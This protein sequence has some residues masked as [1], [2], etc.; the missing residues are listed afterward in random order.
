[1]AGTFRKARDMKEI[2]HMYDMGRILDVL[3]VKN[4]DD[5][6]MI[7]DHESGDGGHNM[8]C[9]STLKTRPLAILQK[10][11]HGATVLTPRN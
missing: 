3:P 7:T 1:V 6:Y 5:F 11:I 4:G 10:W 8:L 9:V 2:M